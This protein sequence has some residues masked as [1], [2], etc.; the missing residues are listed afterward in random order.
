MK[1]QRREKMTIDIFPMR[2]ERRQHYR[3][4]I[5]HSTLGCINDESR[6]IVVVAHN[7]LILLSM[8]SVTTDDKVP[9]YV[10]LFPRTLL[11]AHNLYLGAPV[12]LTNNLSNK[13]RQQQPT[14]THTHHHAH[15]TT[16]TVT[17][18]DTRTSSLALRAYAATRV[19]ENRVHL[20]PDA[21]AAMPANSRLQMEPL[22]PLLVGPQSHELAEAS[23]AT[24]EPP[25]GCPPLDTKLLRDALHGAILAAGATLPLRLNG[26]LRLLTV[27]SVEPAAMHDAAA[28]ASAAARGALVVGSATSIRLG[29][30]LG[31]APSEAAA[32][33]QIAGLQR[34]VEEVRALVKL[35]LLSPSV[36]RELDVAPPRGLLL[37]GPPGTGK[38]LLARS[39]AAN[40]GVHFVPLAGGELLTQN[41][42]EGELQLA[43]AF[44]EAR[45]LAPSILLLDEVDAI[46][47]SRSGPD[48][49]AD[50]RLLAS[51]LSLMDGVGA[52]DGAAPVFVVGTTNRPEALDPALRR[53]GRFDREVH[54]GVPNEASRHEM[55]DA[56]LGR[57]PHALSPRQVEELAAIT[58][59]YVGA[60]LASLLRSA[61]LASLRRSHDSGSV[62]PPGDAVAPPPSVEWGD[63]QEA[64]GRVQPS[65]LR[66]L[67][68]KVP[69]VSWEDIGGQHELK[70]VMHEAVVW[71]L[72]F[73][74][75][76]R[77]MGIRPPRGV[78]MYGPP[79]C[80]KTMVARALAAQSRT[81][82]IA[83]KGPEI[84]SKWVGE[85]EQMLASLFRKARA[86]APSIIFFDEIDALA[87]SRDGASGGGGVGARVLSQLLHEMDGVHELKAVLVVAATNR[88]DLIDPALLRPGR[89]DRLIHVRLPD[90]ASRREILA[91]H[92]RSTPVRGDVRLEQLAQRTVGYSGAELAALCREAAL[93]ALEEDMGAVDVGN[94][95]FENALGVVLPRTPQSLLDIFDEYDRRGSR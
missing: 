76:F 28:A 38:T 84:F 41:M 85:T 78:L 90:E 61:S 95:H 20:H 94:A 5:L 37:Y 29:H 91:V 8:L 32:T 35:P 68:L 45:R 80:S 59:G 73:P 67:E 75:R 50:G 40:L 18:N 25:P 33:E 74:E 65:A 56:L 51:L 52:A 58:V 92:T 54:M 30:P 53:P 39:L 89:F 62:P 83:I 15:A 24:L 71:P 46:G 77:R 7:S 31:D 86:V 82:F 6:L 22:P 43:E 36:F 81:N 12:R 34:L 13:H 23:A 57:L 47:A 64:L 55:L 60:D 42:G 66:E 63:L 27:H 19:R 79:G 87:P 44:E 70:Q 3:L 69:K 48:A 9:R 1:I 88:P 26:E 72:H 17:P 2:V 16:A 93:T 49:A 21:A 11:V 4:V 14:H 10:A